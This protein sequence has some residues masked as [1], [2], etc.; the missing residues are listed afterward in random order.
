ME[1]SLGASAVPVVVAVGVASPTMTS[2]LSCTMSA[3]AAANM[4]AGMGLCVPY[5]TCM[6]LW[7]SSLSFGS[8][9][10]W[11]LLREYTA[12]AAADGNGRCMINKKKKKK[13]DI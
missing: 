2:R 1:Y 12:D 6:R 5:E 3:I 9:M 7:T 8:W 11:L 13:N 4:A 10:R